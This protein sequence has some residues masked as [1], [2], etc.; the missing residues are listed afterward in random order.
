M[1]STTDLLNEK[2]NVFS[3]SHKALI[4]NSGEE[5]VLS[6]STVFWSSAFLLDLCYVLKGSSS[7]A[8]VQL[9]YGSTS[10]FSVTFVI[11]KYERSNST[12]TLKN[13]RMYI[14][15]WT[16]PVIPHYVAATKKISKY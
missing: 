13:L 12:V 5:S 3:S 14:R 6:Y 2:K 7:C 10:D 15:L 9:V 8:T 16:K 4:W 1:E 11:E